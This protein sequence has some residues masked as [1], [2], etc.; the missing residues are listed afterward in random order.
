MVKRKWRKK[1]EL[2]IKIFKNIYSCLIA[3]TGLAEA[4]FMMWELMVNAVIITII[5]RGTKKSEAF[6]DILCANESSHL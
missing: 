6:R 4:A 5:T 1:S 3:S 2:S